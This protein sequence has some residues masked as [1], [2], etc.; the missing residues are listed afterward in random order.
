MKQR[1]RTRRLR[2]QR[3]G[4]LTSENITR[5]ST[6]NR[7][8]IHCISQLKRF[9]VCFQQ[10]D[11]KRLLQ[12]GYNLG[13]LQEL[14]GET[15]HPEVWWKPIETMIQEKSWSELDSYLDELRAGLA[16]E[17]DAKVLASGC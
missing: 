8:I 5:L 9:V 14:C 7:Q 1:Q 17:Y 4:R 12:F 10:G 13:R 2:R 3:A 6:R 16:V 15:T 11:M